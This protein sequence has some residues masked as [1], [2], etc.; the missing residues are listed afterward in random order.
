MKDRT[1]EEIYLSHTGRPSMKWDHYFKIY[2]T[3]FQSFRGASPT[4][5][6]I[7]VRKGGSLEIWR[8]YFGPG[9]KVVGVDINPEC[10][11]MEVDG[12]EI[13]IGD[14]GNPAFLTGLAE[15]SGP[16]DIIIDDGSHRMDDLRTSFSTLFP[17]L[18]SGGL[19]LVE[20]THTCYMEEYGGGFQEP[21]SFIE[22][23][24]TIIDQMHA[25]Y[26]ED[27]STFGPNGLT[28]TVNATHF[29]DSIVVIE[30]INRFDE[31]TGAVVKR[32]GLRSGGAVAPRSS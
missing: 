4:V 28:V 19:Y 26:S 15:R 20:D 29:Y 9:C 7:G 30:K 8:D 17:L 27:R 21:G 1:F 12:F 5:L 31:V 24:K 6:E 18:N 25:F 3:H 2:D 10:R 14:Q 22:N 13:Y 32:E 16:F 23:A 11:E